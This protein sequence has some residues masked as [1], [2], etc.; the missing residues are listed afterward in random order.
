[1]GI[2]GRQNSRTASLTPAVQV[3]L[4][5]DACMTTNNYL[6]SLL[7][8]TSTAATAIITSDQTPPP[9]SP[10]IGRSWRKY[11]FCCDKCF[12]ATNTNLSPQT[13]VCRDKTHLLSR[14]KYACCD[15][16]FVARKYF[17]ATNIC[18]DKHVFVAIKIILEA[19]P[20]IYNPH[21]LPSLSTVYFLF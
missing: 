11:H 5:T 14:Q 13:R 15:E 4:Y 12:V 19:A 17:F 2:T 8:F 16:S 7:N 6:F 20:A 10:I 9:P 21:P 1:M 18:R 3:S